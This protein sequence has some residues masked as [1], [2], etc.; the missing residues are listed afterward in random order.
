MKS[1]NG[2]GV[3]FAQ[4]SRTAT[5][6]HVLNHA[7]GLF[8]PNGQSLRHGSVEDNIFSL[9]NQRGMQIQEDDFSLTSLHTEGGS[10]TKLYLFSKKKVGPKIWAW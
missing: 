8:F 2:G 5:Y 6:E 10:R 4:L 1:Q 9:A 3:V 7:K